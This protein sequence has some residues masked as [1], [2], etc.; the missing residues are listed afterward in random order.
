MY[1]YMYMYMHVYCYLVRVWYC[2][3][4]RSG[5]SPSHPVAYRNV[6]MGLPA[7]VYPTP[8][9]RDSASEAGGEV[10]FTLYIQ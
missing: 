8:L 10:P 3:V 2:Q 6:P 7:V 9:D 1:M 4:I 5:R